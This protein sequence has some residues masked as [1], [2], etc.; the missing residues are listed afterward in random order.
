MPIG[1]LAGAADHEL[2]PSFTI[3]DATA[4]L[5]FPHRNR[6]SYFVRND[7]TRP[8]GPLPPHSRRLKHNHFSILRRSGEPPHDRP[9]RLGGEPELLLEVRQPFADDHDVTAA[10]DRAAHGAV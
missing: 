5:D 10:A 4:T 8:V 3:T 6:S 9:L 1:L 7:G 2:R